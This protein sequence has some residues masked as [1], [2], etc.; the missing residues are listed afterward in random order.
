MKVLNNLYKEQLIILN[1]IE[2]NTDA[3]RKI[4]GRLTNL[5]TTVE[6]ERLKIN[7]DMTVLRSNIS[8]L[9]QAATLKW[10]MQNE[11]W[12]HSTHWIRIGQFRRLYSTWLSQS[13]AAYDRNQELERTISSSRYASSNVEGIISNVLAHT[14]ACFSH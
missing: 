2:Q 10:F 6:K 4:T 8:N 7:A 13:D 12:W 5:E 14:E 1:S 11:L 9:S 3:F